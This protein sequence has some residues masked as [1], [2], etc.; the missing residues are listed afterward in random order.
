MAIKFSD[1]VFGANV[2][3][4]IIDIF[5][6]LQKGSFD[7]KPLS[8]TTV[9]KVFNLLRLEGKG[10]GSH[11]ILLVED[12][13][14]QSEFLSKYLIEHDIDVVKAFSGKEA[15]EK[16]ETESI[17]GIILD[18][19]L[20]DYNGLDLLDEIKLNAN[21]A[22]IPVVVNTAQ[23]LSREDLKRLMEYIRWKESFNRR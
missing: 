19:R 21:W 16:L 13:V 15:I 1:R 5:D 11:K 8:E 23:E 6:N 22:L 9:K 4:K 20:P 2:E 3:K 14:F 10:T 17:D 18:M 7:Q 12:D